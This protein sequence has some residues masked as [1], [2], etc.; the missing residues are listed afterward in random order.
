MNISIPLNAFVN[1]KDEFIISDIETSEKDILNK[2]NTLE[3]QST[4]SPMYLKE[5]DSVYTTSGHVISKDGDIFIDEQGRKYEIDSSQTI[6]HSIDLSNLW[7]GEITSAV[8]DRDNEIIYSTWQTDYAFY[9]IST[10]VENTII[11]NVEIPIKDSELNIVNFAIKAIDTNT[12]AFIRVYT[13]GTSKV[14]VT[15][16]SGNLYDSYTTSYLLGKILTVNPDGYIGIDDTD[17][18][19]RATFLFSNNTVSLYT[20][21]WGCVGIN[22]LITGEPIPMKNSE[23]E[24]ILT[25]STG[26]NKLTNFD[27]YTF[28][29]NGIGV[30]ENAVNHDIADNTALK[31]TSAFNTTDETIMTWNSKDHSKMAVVYVAGWDTHNSKPLIVTDTLESSYMFSPITEYTQFKTTDDYSF[32]NA[33]SHSFY[34]VDFSDGFGNLEWTNGTEPTIQNGCNPFPYAYSVFNR[35]ESRNVY[36]AYGPGWAKSYVRRVQF[37]NYSGKKAMTQMFPTAIISFGLKSNTE[38]DDNAVRLEYLSPISFDTTHTTYTIVPDEEHPHAFSRQFSKT[39]GIA[40]SRVHLFNPDIFT[41]GMVWVDMLGAD[42]LPNHSIIGKLPFNVKLNHKYFE[43]YY[44]FNYLST[45]TARTLITSASMNYKESSYI[46]NDAIYSNG[47]MVVL[48]DNGEVKLEKIAD[49]IYKTNTL[50]GNNLFI[51]GKENFDGQRGFIPYNGEEIINLQSVYSFSAPTDN[52]DTDGNSTYYTAA[53]YNIDLSSPEKR[54]SSY[55]LPEAVIPL[56]IRSEEQQDFTFQLIDNKKEITKPFIYQFFDYKDD[57]VD[58]YYNHSLNSTSVEYQTGKK[59]QSNS[60]NENEKL[61][62]IA[63]FDSDKEGTVWWTSQTVNIFPLGLANKITGINYIS[64]TVNLT[65]DYTVRLYRRFNTTFPVYNPFTEVYKGSTI[66]TIYG[67]NYS[68]DGQA[69]YFLGAGDDTS[70]TNFSCYALGMQFL[71]NSGTEAYFYSSFEKRI[72]LF[73]GSVTLQISDSLAREGKI[74]DSLYSSL[75]Q[76]LYLLTEEGNIIAKTQKDM[77]IIDKIDSSL[78][79]FESTDTGMILAGDW[80][81]RRYRLYKTDETQWRPFEYETEFIGKNNSFLRISNIDIT[82]FRGDCQRIT[83]D[84]FFECLSDQMPLKEKQ[85]FE[86]VKTD[87]NSSALFKLRFV[88]K[89]NVCKA[90]RFGLKSKDEN[91]HIANVAVN[92]EELSQNT[93]SPE[94]RGHK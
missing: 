32:D 63:T 53:G 64:S 36:W 39:E 94:A 82:F 19:K 74:V 79:H 80:K 8:Y 93:N 55:I 54:A 49:Y 24:T 18:R 75:E 48:E 87:W 1:T 81:F 60:S 68:F 76:T 3:F 47:L 57:S 13:N 88:P 69:I 22:G 5:G 85:N 12:Y 9:I 28:L 89:D 40:F 6:K 56:V 43:Q 7:N 91:V 83:G 72:Y 33:G 10:D 45:S 59:L 20:R 26:W 11:N 78:Y 61:Y 30:L 41:N 77:A 65:D 51:D 71:A 17:V 42:N 25:P 37:R 67:Y 2:K 44:Q 66:F 90:F 31:E 62:G 46:L 21:G 4:L 92:V 14:S 34:Q 52:Q 73:T 84:L 50:N 15:D 16:K 29:E 23:S 27:N 86:I 38:D 70:Q 58:H 35:A